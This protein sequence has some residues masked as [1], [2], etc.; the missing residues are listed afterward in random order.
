[1]CNAAKYSAQQAAHVGICSKVLFLC[2][3]CGAPAG[4]IDILQGPHLCTSLQLNA[5]ICLVSSALLLL[6]L[7]L[8]RTLPCCRLL[9]QF[10][11]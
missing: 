9:L 1:V 8:L 11:V 2:L 5:V 7:L 4:L 3:P 10:V 6:L